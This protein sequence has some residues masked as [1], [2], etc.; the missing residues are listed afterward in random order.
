MSERKPSRLNDLAALN[1]DALL[2]ASAYRVVNSDRIHAR[3]RFRLRR[4]DFDHAV[5]VVY[6]EERIPEAVGSR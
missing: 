4:G 5:L 1:F 3:E 6:R 2:H